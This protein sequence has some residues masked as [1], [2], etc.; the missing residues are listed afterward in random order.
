MVEVFS[1]MRMPLFFAAS[2]LFPAEWVRA[3]WRELLAGKLALLIWVFML[4]QAVVFVYKVAETLWLPN[5]PE[6]SVRL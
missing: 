4:W 6:S 5:Q 3:T 1:T 2:G